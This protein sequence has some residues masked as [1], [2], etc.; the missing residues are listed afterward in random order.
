[1]EDTA[2][3]ATYGLRQGIYQSN[4][5][6]NSDGGLTNGAEA[7]KSAK[8]NPIKIP[9]LVVNGNIAPYV[10]DYGIGDRVMVK[11]NDHPLINDINGMFRIEKISINIDNDDNET[12]TLQVSQ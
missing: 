9:A 1:A 3:Q 4:A 5:T 2:S 8:S 11:I 6:D 7:I 10:T 12:V